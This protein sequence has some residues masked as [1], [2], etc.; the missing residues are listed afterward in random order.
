[1]STTWRRRLNYTLCVCD[2]SY[3]PWGN[4]QK[5][6]QRQSIHMKVRFL[7]GIWSIRDRW[8]LTSRYEAHGR[9]CNNYAEVLWQQ[10]KHLEPEL[11]NRQENLLR[12]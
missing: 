10:Y 7:L 9:P 4:L 11:R 3:P 1:M 5:Y 8:T 6:L 12:W 2:L